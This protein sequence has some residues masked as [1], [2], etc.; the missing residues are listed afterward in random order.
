MSL[1]N[2]LVGSTE[3]SALPPGVDPQMQEAL[4]PSQLSH[5]LSE[6]APA[7]LGKGMIQVGFKDEATQMFEPW[8][9]TIQGAVNILGDTHVWR[10]EIDI[11]LIETADDML[12][13]VD[14]LHVAFE[15]AETHV[16]SG[17][18]S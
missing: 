1:L 7:T 17:A 6:L 12:K 4:S 14:Q 10:A 13:L 9:V 2:A 18:A 3:T 11:R 16:R 5:L 8:L 15:Q